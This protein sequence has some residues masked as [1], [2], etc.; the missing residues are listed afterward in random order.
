MKTYLIVA[1]LAA[2]ALASGC[3]VLKSA[4]GVAVEKLGEGIKKYCEADVSAREV[5]RARVNADAAPNSIRVECAADESGEAGT[6]D[7][8]A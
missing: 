4:E 3:S 1:M 7:T 2:F 5:V 6:R 8:G